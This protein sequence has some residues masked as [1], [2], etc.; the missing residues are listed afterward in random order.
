[1]ERAAGA[2][3]P[4]HDSYGIPL[5]LKL[6][7]RRHSNRIMAMTTGSVGHCAMCGHQAARAKMAAHLAAVGVEE[8]RRWNLQETGMSIWDDM[9][10]NDAPMFSRTFWS[11][12]ISIW[13]MSRAFF[14]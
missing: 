12:S 10:F 14:L 1:M 13:I 5:Q 3:L 8:I 9:A 4:P 11:A 2:A 6:V 7:V